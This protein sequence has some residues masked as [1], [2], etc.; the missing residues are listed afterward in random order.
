MCK[1]I[2]VAVIKISSFSVYVK[3]N[4]Y[5]FKYDYFNDFLINSLLI[6]YS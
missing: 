2:T 5:Y 4:C 3:I 1:F 6:I